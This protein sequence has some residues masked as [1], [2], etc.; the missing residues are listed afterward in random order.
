M[1]SSH[2]I[3]AWLFELMG[4]DVALTGDLEE[5]ARGRSVIWYWRQVLIAI[6]I[7]TWGVILHNKLLAFRAVATGCAVN[8]VW[9]F[10]W[11]KFVPSLGFPLTPTISIELIPYL[12]IILLAHSVTGWVVARTHRTHPVPMVGVFAIWLMAW[13]VGNAVPYIRG[14]LVYSDL[15]NQT[16]FSRLYFV[17][18]AWYSLPE[19]AV[20]TGLLVGGILGARPKSLSAPA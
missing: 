9:L 8:S 15:T 19:F 12:L 1:K 10:L 13:F 18:V 17:S 11:R 4:I 20:V 6:W 16:G 7:G 2:S 5:C 14:L 3:A